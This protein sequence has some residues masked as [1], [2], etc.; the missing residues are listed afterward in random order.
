MAP[1]RCK[2]GVQY[3][4]RCCSICRGLP[5]PTPIT[6]PRKRRVTHDSASTNMNPLKLCAGLAQLQIGEK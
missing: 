3:A 5:D 6:A 4:H 2:H 1:H